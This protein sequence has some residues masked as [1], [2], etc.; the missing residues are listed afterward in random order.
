MQLAPS[1]AQLADPAVAA[2]AAVAHSEL[3]LLLCREEPSRCVVLVQHHNADL[4][5]LN[6]IHGTRFCD[7]GSC[8]SLCVFYLICKLTPGEFF[9]LFIYLFLINVKLLYFFLLN[10]L[11]ID[12]VVCGC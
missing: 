8:N 7:L 11:F 1:V 2:T 12:I 5:Y 3:P 9:Y 10:L 6:P 4:I